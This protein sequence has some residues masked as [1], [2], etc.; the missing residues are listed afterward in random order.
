[1]D[2]HKRRGLRG[3]ESTARRRHFEAAEALDRLEK[4]QVRELCR[5]GVSIFID[6]MHGLFLPA[7]AQATSVAGRPLD[8]GGGVTKTIADVIQEPARNSGGIS[9]ADNAI[10]AIGRS[11]SCSLGLTAHVCRLSGLSAGRYMPSGDRP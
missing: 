1:M 3:G 2:S 8:L 4:Y 11:M 9:S 6:Q 7:C 10:T 5:G